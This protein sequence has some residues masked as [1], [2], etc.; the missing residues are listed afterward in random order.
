VG[1]IRTRAPLAAALAAAALGAAAPAASAASCSATGSQTVR[2]TPFARIYYDLRAR[3]FSCYRL[4]GRRVALD[5]QVDRFYAPGDAHLGL[6]RIAGRMLGYTWIDPGIPA[7]Y[8]HSVD[9]RTARFKHRTKIEPL[10]V[11][12][13]AAVAVPQIVV[14]T[15]GSIAWVQKVEGV[16]SV[17]R[18]DRRG[19]K[20]VGGN[21]AKR[22]TSLRLRGTRLTWR[23]AGVLRAS[24]LV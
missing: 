19:R 1:G 17:W 9:M 22:V 20:R 5:T 7:V 23:R 24:R 2:S 3:P 13:P 12:D 6:V 11:I 21:T 15:G 16:S 8:V 10:V 18:W 4:T 14:N